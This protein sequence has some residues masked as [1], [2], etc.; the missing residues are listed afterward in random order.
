MTLSKIKILRAIQQH[1]LISSEILNNYLKSIKNTS[2][3]SIFNLFTES[4]IQ[5]HSF[6]EAY[7]YIQVFL[8][9]YFKLVKYNIQDQFWIVL[10]LVAKLYSIEQPDIK[11]LINTYKQLPPIQNTNPL[12]RE[13]KLAILP[14]YIQAD[15]N[16][17]ALIE[18]IKQLV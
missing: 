2:Y 1:K 16:Y 6:P 10:L 8:N 11:L 4:N 9:N 13:V 18:E 5:F 12:K 14:F 3:Q 17:L 15:D 7:S